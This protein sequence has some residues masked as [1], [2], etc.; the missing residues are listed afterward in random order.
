[1]KREPTSEECDQYLATYKQYV[2]ENRELN[3]TKYLLERSFP[4]S[5][6]IFIVLILI[7]TYLISNKWYGIL[8]A[9][10]ILLIAYESIK[11]FLINL[12]SSGKYKQVKRQLESL[13]E[14]TKAKTLPFEETYKAYFEEKLK[15]FY[16]EKLFR[17]RSGTE[18][19][20][21]AISDFTIMLEEA[22]AINSVFL[23]K[24]VDLKNYES[25]LI[26]RV[27]ASLFQ[28][29]HADNR[30]SNYTKNLVAIKDSKNEVPPTIKVIPP[31]S[32][33]STPRHVDWELI[34]K[35]KKVVGEHGEQIVMAIEQNYLRSINRPDLAEKVRHFS[36]EEGDGSGYDILSFSNEGKLKYIEVKSTKSSIEVP[37][38]L[39]RNEM[40]FLKNNQD[41]AFI[42][43]VLNVD[44]KD[45]K[46]LL[47]V[48]TASEVL[49][50]NE[51]IPVQYLVN[52]KT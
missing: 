10:W 21:S 13:R 36:K 47:K 38:Y 8:I 52:M 3:H 19:F 16:E 51:I 29:K 18:Q 1:M 42:Y 24:T 31:E 22:R 41:K 6:A 25:Y 33:Y 11:N 2:E 32:Y 17:K 49:N 30:L 23:T 9:G 4:K 34:N 44:E 5:L 20:E 35:A 26:G 46:P 45:T 7:A 12:I 40:F 37:F 50:S 27:G 39:S 48:Y 15:T 14:S 43:R 28:R